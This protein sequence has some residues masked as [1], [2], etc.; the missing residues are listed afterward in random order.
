MELTAQNVHDVIKDCLFLDG[1]EME[2]RAESHG[3][4]RSFAFHPE[5]L[6]SHREDV[7]SMLMQLHPTFR[8]TAGG[9]WSFLN[10]CIR[11]EDE[12]DIWGEQPTVN[13]LFCLGQ[14][15]GLGEYTPRQRELWPFFPGSVPY[16]VVR[17]G[18]DDGART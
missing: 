9:G 15:L 8:Q 3:I 5:R 1:E 14:A 16:Y 6:E 12:N 13:E 10:G 7:R 17:D 11:G 4:V 2:P 18:E